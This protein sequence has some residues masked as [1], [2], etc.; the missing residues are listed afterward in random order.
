MPA[1]RLL[2]STKY[3]VTAG[4][5][6]FGRLRGTS[7]PLSRSPLR[8]SPRHRWRVDELVCGEVRLKLLVFYRVDRED[9]AA[10]LAIDRAGSHVAVIARLEDHGS[11]PG[12]HVHAECLRD[13]TPPIGRQ[14][15]PGLI[16]VPR[17]GGRRRGGFTDLEALSCAYAFY[18]VE[19]TGELL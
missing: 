2:S 8:L 9:F 17:V 12:L 6:S 11:H 10:W 3:I 15:Y 5:W 4:R 14:V 19:A 13:V 1:P 7:F 18:R 16:K